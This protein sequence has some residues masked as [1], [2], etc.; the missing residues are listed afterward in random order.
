MEV[1]EKVA[2]VALRGEEINGTLKD[3]LPL[4]PDGA[5]VDQFRTRMP[6]FGDDA[7]LDRLQR[8]GVTLRVLQ[9][10]EGNPLYRLLIL[11]VPWLLL[12]AFFL[13]VSRRTSRYLGGEGATRR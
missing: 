4:G 5:R 3:P 10:T 1:R 8:N 2:E 6:A 7:L 11:T 13:W 9:T 12:I